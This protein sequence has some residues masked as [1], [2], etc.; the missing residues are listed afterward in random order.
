LFLGTLTVPFVQAQVPIALPTGN[1]SVV[2]NGFHGTLTITGIGALGNIAA[3]STIFGNP[4]IGFYDSTSAN[5]NFIRII[6][7][8]PSFHQIYTGYLFRDIPNPARFVLTGDFL[9]YQGTGG[10]AKRPRFGWFAT[11]P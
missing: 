3:G 7:G 8:N 5:I 6:G 9:A 11:K 2:A 4:I 10:T 1:W